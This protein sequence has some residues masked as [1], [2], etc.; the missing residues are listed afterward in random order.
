MGFRIFS[1]YVSD[2]SALANSDVSI[3]NK[4]EAQTKINNFI[5]QSKNVLDNYEIT[6]NGATG[7]YVDSDNFYDKSTQITGAAG[8]YKI[9]NQKFDSDPKYDLQTNGSG[10]SRSDIDILDEKSQQYI[11]TLK[12]D[13]EGNITV[14]KDNRLLE[15]I[16]K[17]SSSIS[18]SSVKEFNER[19]NLVTN[20]INALDRNLGSD[21]SGKAWYNEGFE[22]NCIE[23]QQAFKLGFGGADTLRSAALN[24]K[25]N[26]LLA[27]R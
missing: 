19:T 10:A 24:I 27:D 23:Y 14:Y 1:T 15:T 9:A 26:G 22:I 4:S 6:M 16:K 25:A 3:L 11:W 18:N 5:T 8:S 2:K 21:R 13:A 12:A 17:T 20:F 7:I